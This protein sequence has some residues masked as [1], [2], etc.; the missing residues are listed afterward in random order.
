MS[1]LDHTNRTTQ[2]Y[3]LPTSSGLQT[4]NTAM[5]VSGPVLFFNLNW[6]RI[7]GLLALRLNFS[8][9]GYSSVANK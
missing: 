1:R 9:V 6:Q 4:P 2:L 7:D 8:S 3:G 5:R